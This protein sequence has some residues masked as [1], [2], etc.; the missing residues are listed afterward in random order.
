[1]KPVDGL[2]AERIL[3]WKQ[4]GDVAS[5]LAGLPRC[6]G[7]ARRTAF[8]ALQELDQRIGWAMV[9]VW[10][11]GR[12]D[13]ETPDQTLDRLWE[14]VALSGLTAGL[15]SEVPRVRAKAAAGMAAL[16]K[17]E[18]LGTLLSRMRL[19]RKGTVL[20]AMEAAV[21]ELSA[22]PG[23][24]DVRIRFWAETGQWDRIGRLGSDAATALADMARDRTAADRDTRIAR[25]RAL[26]T[27]ARIEPREAMDIVREVLESDR[28][29]LVLEAAARVLPEVGTPRDAPLLAGLLGSTDEQRRDAAM[30]ALE[31]LGGRA[32]VEVLEAYAAGVTSPEV[33]IALGEKVARMGGS[34]DLLASM[35][36]HGEPSIRASAAAA[37][38]RTG[39]VEAIEVL[40]PLLQDAYPSVRHEATVAMEA[41]GWV[42]VGYVRQWQT[43]AVD[44]WTVP[45]D[46]GAT[47][48]FDQ[49]NLMI[50]G[51]G[52]RDPI[53][54]RAAADMLGRLGAE[55]A[56]GPLEELLASEPDPT[57]RLAAARSLV[58]LGRP[59]QAGP[60]WAP[61]NAMEG[62]W[63][64]VIPHPEEA[65]A[66]VAMV[67]EL[68]DPGMRAAALEAAAKVDHPRATELLVQGLSDP[69]QRVRL[70]ATRGLATGRDHR[71][72]E[73]LV[74]LLD[75]PS[76]GP[77][78]ADALALARGRGAEALAEAARTASPA[79]R[80]RAVTLLGAS[81]DPSHL[82]TLLTA[83]KDEA[84]PVREAA[85]EGLGK[86]REQAATEALAELLD[87][88]PDWRVR[89]QAAR[90][91]GEARAGE[92][93]LVAALGDTFQE[94]RR[95]ALEALE[96]MGVPPAPELMRAVQALADE[97]WS[98]LVAIG[99]AAVPLLVRALDEREAD[100]RTTKTK[101][102]AAWA[103]GQIR[104]DRG[105]PALVLALQDPNPEVQAAAARAL[106]ELGA[107]SALP[108]I[109]ALAD[110]RDPEIRLAVLDALGSLGPGQAMDVVV[111][112]MDDPDPR[113]REKATRILGKDQEVAFD[114]LMEALSARDPGVRAAAAQ[115]LGTMGD[116][117][118]I[119]PLIELLG[120][121]ER[122][123]RKA[124][125]DALVALGWVPIGWRASRFDRGYSFWTKR[126]YWLG[127]DP[128]ASQ[129]ELL[130]AALEDPDPA[131]RRNA[132]EGLGRVGDRSAVGP[133]KTLVDDPSPHVAVVAC[134]ALVDLGEQPLVE[135]AWAPY[136][137]AR[138][139]WDTAVAIGAASV[140]HLAAVLEEPDAS[141]DRK[142]GAMEAL[143]RI[144]GDAAKVALL[145]GLEDPDPEPRG[146]AAAALGD[147]GAADAVGPLCAALEHRDTRHRV[148]QALIRIGPPA[149][150]RLVGLLKQA[151]AGVASAAAKILGEIG[152][153]TG[154][155]ALVEAM[156]RQEADVRAAAARA[157][158]ECRA[159]PAAPRLT[160]AVTA[161][162]A[163]RV[164]L[165]AA[166]ALGRVGDG[167]QAL[168]Q[169]LADPYPDVVRACA[170]AMEAIG[171]PPEPA[172]MNA[173]WA[174]SEERWDD[175]VAVGRAAIP[176]LQVVLG[177]RGTDHATCVRRCEAAGALAR[178]GATEATDGLVEATHAQD[179]RVVAAAARALGELGA[180]DALPRLVELARSPD[181]GVRAAAVAALG[182]IDPEGTMATIEA[183]M[184]DPAPEVR[185]AAVHALGKEGEIAFARLLEA[186]G[187]PDP[188]MR[189]AAAQTLGDLGDERG[190]DPL[191]RALSDSDS[192]VALAAKAALAKL[193]WMPV[194]WRTR[195]TDKGYAYWTTRSEWVEGLGD[196][197]QRDALEHALASS[198]D[199]VRRRV[200][201]EGLG[202]LG[203]DRAIPALKRALEEDQD[204]DVRIVAARSVVDLGGTPEVSPVWLPFWIDTGKWDVC[205]KIARK[206]PKS[207]MPELIGV[208]AGDPD[209]AHRMGVVQVLA[210]V[211][212][213]RAVEAL[214]SAARDHNPSV[215]EAALDALAARR[216]LPGGILED[217]ASLLG[218]DRALDSKIAAL[219]GSAFPAEEALRLVRGLAVHD[220]PARRVAAQI[221]AGYVQDPGAIQ[222]CLDGMVDPLARVRVAAIEALARRKAQDAGQRLV[223]VALGDP[224]WRVRRAAVVALGAIWEGQT[225]DD[226]VLDGLVAALGDP[227]GEVRSEAIRVAT[228]LG[229]PPGDGLLAAARAMAAGRWNEVQAHGHEAIPLL[230]RALMERGDDLE[231]LRT[232]AAAAR[233]LGR[234]HAPGAKELLLDMLGEQ[235]PRLRRAA[236]E[237]L[238]GLGDPTVGGAL[239]EAFQAADH[240][241]EVREA[242]VD[243][244]TRLDAP[245]T[246]DVIPLALGDPDPRVRAAGSRA[247]G[248]PGLME[249][250]DLIAALGSPDPDVRRDACAK[251]GELGDP[252]AIDPLNERLA[253]SHLPV[254]M[255]ARAALLALGWH[256]VGW[257][258]TREARG[259]SYWTFKSEWMG[260]DPD[261]PQ[262]SMLVRALDSEDPNRRRN[263]AEALGLMAATP[264]L[265]ALTRLAE[266]D[267]DEDVRL[268]AGDSLSL[269][270]E[271]QARIAGLA[272]AL[273][274]QLE[275]AAD[276]DMVID[277]SLEDDDQAMRV[278]AVRVLLARR[279]TR[280]LVSLLEHRAPE[281]RVEAARALGELGGD[282]AIRAL[283]R[284]LPDTLVGEAA[285][286]ALAKAGAVDRLVAATQSDSPQV[287]K[288]AVAALGHAG[289]DP[290]HVAKLLSDRDPRVRAACVAALAQL[291]HPDGRLVTMVLDDPDPWARAAA[292][293]A[294]GRLRLD[295]AQDAL[296]LAIADPARAVADAAL[297]ALSAT[298]APD[299]DEAT[300]IHGLISSED[301]AGCVQAPDWCRELLVRIVSTPPDGPLEVRRR[302]GAAWALG[303]LGGPAETLA[304][305]LES[306]RYDEQAVAAEALGKIGAKRVTAKVRGLVG[307]P[308]PGVRAASLEALGKLGDEPALRLMVEALGDDDPGVRLAA[309][310]ALGYMGEAGIGPLVDALRYEDQAMVLEACAS[311]A[312]IRDQRVIEDLVPL[313]R[314]GSPEVRAAAKAALEALG[315]TPVDVRLRAREMIAAAESEDPADRAAAAQALGVLGVQEAVPTL[316]AMLLDEDWGVRAAAGKAL[317]SL[318]RE[319]AREPAWVP[320]FAATGAW[321]DLIAMGTQGIEGL[322]HE[323]QDRSWPRRVQAMEALGRASGQAASDALKA[324]LDDPV[325]EVRVAAAK[326][327]ATAGA[328]EAVELLASRLGDEDAQPGIAEALSKFGEAMVE[329]ATRLLTDGDA[330][331]ARWAAT[332]LGMARI[333]APGLVGALDH[334]APEVR[335]AAAEAL[336]NGG[337]ASDLVID[338]L[339]DSF[340][341][342]PDP[343]VRVAAARA[344]GALGEGAEVLW[345]Y[346]G[347]QYG[348]VRRACVEALEAMG[349]PADPTLVAAGEAVAARRWAEV[350]RYGEVAV[351][352]LLQALAT[353]GLDRDSAEVRAGAALTLG[354]LG[355]TAAI[356]TLLEK[357]LRDQQ[358]A[359]RAAAA[360]ALG[361]LRAIEALPAIEAL[362]EDLDPAVRRAAYRAVADISGDGAVL[363]RGLDDPD[364]DVAATCFELLAKLDLAK[365]LAWAEVE[366][367]NPG[368]GRK[369]DIVE[370]LERLGRVEGVDVL[371]PLLDDGDPTVRRRAKEAMT[372]LGWLPVG[373]QRPGD[374]GVSYWTRRSDWDPAGPDEPQVSIMM[375]ALETSTDPEARFVAVRALGQLGDPTALPALRKALQQDESWDV[376]AEAGHALVSLGEGPMVTPAWLP[377][378]VSVEG[379]DQCRRLAPKAPG[380]AA[381]GVGAKAAD[382]A[383]RDRLAAVD[384]LL[385]IDHPEAV[386]SLLEL[387]RDRDPDVQK[388]ALTGLVEHR[389][390][391]DRFLE[392][393]DDPELGPIGVMALS[394]SLADLAR[395]EVKS[396]VQ[397]GTGEAR[398]RAIQIWLVIGDGSL[399][400]LDG[401]ETKDPADMARIL[402]LLDDLGS[403]DP[404]VRRRAVAG[405][406][407]YRDPGTAA[408]LTDALLDPEVSVQAGEVLVSMGVQPAPEP[409]WL[410]YLAAKGDWSTISRVG[411][412]A[413]ETLRGILETDPAQERRVGA[414]GALAGIPG[415]RSTALLV[416]AS[417]DPAPRVR[418][419]AAKALSA[420]GWP[421]AVE[422]LSGLLGDPDCEPEVAQTLAGLGPEAMDELVRVLEA[423]GPEART[424]A[425]VALGQ[426][427]EASALAPLLAAMDNPD[428]QVRAAA[429]R[430]LGLLGMPSAVD[431]LIAGVGDPKAEVR[432]AC[433]KALG[434]IGDP[435]AVEHL[436]PALGDGFAKVRSAVREALE[437]LGE[438]PDPE[439]LAAAE[440][441]ASERW[442]ALAAR[443]PDALVLVLG[444][445]GS[446]GL[447][448]TSAQTRASAAWVLGELGDQRAFEP[449][450]SALRDPIPRVQASAAL[451]LGRLGDQ[452]AEPHLV[453]AYASLAPEVRVA[454]LK[455]LGEIGTDLATRLFAGALD[456]P[457]PE[458]RAV[459]LTLLGRRDELAAADWLVQKL[460]E[461]DQEE[462]LSAIE[463]LV[464][465][466]A[467]RGIDG[468]VFC[469][470]D[471]SPAVRK[472][473]W[474]ALVA[475]GWYPI[476]WR[477]RR[478][479]PG[480]AYW[481]SRSDW[482][483]ATGMPEASTQKDILLEALAKAEDPVRR[484]VAAE[485][486]G[487]LGDP[488]ALPG[489]ER[490]MGSDPDEDVRIVA[491]QSMVRLGAE[492]THDRVWLPYWVA[493]G[494]WDVCVELHAVRE[495]ERVLGEPDARR[496]RGAIEA[497]ARIPGLD[498]GL[499]LVG[500]ATRD[501][502]LELRLLAL[503]GLEGHREPEVAKGL[504]ALLATP[505]LQ[506][507]VEE[508]LEGVGVE[509]VV[510]DL[511]RILQDGARP[512]AERASAARS[513]S[514]TSGAGE[515]LR[516]ALGAREGEVRAAA[517]HGLARLGAG[518]DLVRTITAAL[519]RDRDPM[520]RE[521]AAYALGKLG[522]KDA[523]AD[524]VGGMGDA[525]RE[526]RD[527]C[528]R[529]LEDLGFPPSR[530]VIEAS[531]AMAMERW[532]QVSGPAELLL[533]ALDDPATDPSAVERKANAALALGRSRS[534]KAKGVLLG[535]LTATEA[536]LVAAAAEALGVL[537]DPSA[538][539]ALAS[540]FHAP[541]QD[542][543]VRAAVV[544]GCGALDCQACKEVV[545]DALGDPDD[546]IRAMAFEVM[547]KPDQVLV[548][549]LI[550]AL[551]DSD[552]SV[553]EQ[554]AERLGAA[555]RTMAIDPLVATLGDAVPEVRR[556][557]K[558]ALLAL[559]WHPIGWRAHPDDKG[560]AYWTPRS[561]WLGADPDEPQVSMLIRALDHPD[562]DTRRNA[563]EALGIIGD[564]AAVGKL[565]TLA[566]GDPDPEVAAVA[567]QAL[568]DLRVKVLAARAEE[569]AREEEAE[570]EGVDE[571]EQQPPRPEG[572]ADALARIVTSVFTDAMDW[573]AGGTEGAGESSPAP[574]D[575]ARDPKE[576]DGPGAGPEPRDT[577]GAG[578][579]E[580]A[581]EEEQPEAAPEPRDTEGAGRA[582]EA[583]EEEQPEAHGGAGDPSGP[584]ETRAHAQAS[585]KEP[586]AGTTAPEPGT[587]EASTSSE[588]R[589]GEPDAPE[590][591]AEPD[592]KGGGGS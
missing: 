131:R 163:W 180:R 519:H 20:E 497:L 487:M 158:G 3:A 513:I 16:G 168:A 197:S 204:V 51:L 207:S 306:P 495:L 13:D 194:G 351:D 222:V 283:E 212:S 410:P 459:A 345:R 295:G 319:P 191:L 558:R 407:A 122:P 211:K 86:L 119:D 101:A 157:L 15:E 272:R 250:Q 307:S 344:L 225:P 337:L 45:S 430:G 584:L 441:L 169:G 526:V 282:E 174:I 139:D 395:P 591:G 468:L 589:V 292:A 57:V 223:D 280:R 224:S 84:A 561:M 453:R 560:Y 124:A 444:A 570:E 387:S 460:Y 178:L 316:E 210:R 82:D 214:L 585:T 506:A 156:D 393:L 56:S 50:R 557:A 281:V 73:R 396:L 333:E 47:G 447:D 514:R 546:R 321:D 142:A 498:A 141:P 438:A 257:R 291:G 482:L 338:A 123:V 418:M 352:L 138:G 110:H 389:E 209:P 4:L 251:L 310:R 386:E 422:I 576:H 233:T 366:I 54:R 548:E 277:V 165:E 467:R 476:G 448:R 428:G 177:E 330:T 299:L 95:A 167:V 271:T 442:E 146:A 475:L 565:E 65:V 377:Y 247:L 195:R 196:V 248:A 179:T 532:E 384:V 449:L 287:R 288:V 244:L 358:P 21:S 2:R 102:M 528:R 370:A 33:T 72:V 43:G 318:G 103:L 415:E 221:A 99:R 303:E 322:L 583:R 577:E 409:R 175:C 507:R 413:V 368:S 67:L 522:A 542:P 455:A 108:G 278:A 115:T 294:L 536:K 491:A 68:D 109:L 464:D 465:L 89:A 547:G 556:A 451:A 106:G 429:A 137:V 431:R 411:E 326:G 114:T 128:D 302:L 63:R 58:K 523:V 394:G 155:D 39:R 276:P 416:A 107:T 380:A 254:R 279:E 6:E 160:E 525:Y 289:A 301:W 485:G 572:L 133:L 237:G 117:R 305:L 341:R 26:E 113:V 188:G 530:E 53:M 421:A 269:I 5:I 563:A 193:G 400:V 22:L 420:R 263:A 104:D 286:R 376:R 164:R 550:Q 382:P 474:D 94:V 479:D 397:T 412:A 208:L 578:R 472:A 79:G 354:R 492:P 186:L 314:H 486:L 463:A 235:D 14:Q 227:Y 494:G 69:D 130:V 129:V 10:S 369:L 403:D 151:P 574:E 350:E 293:T 515:V 571:E 297:S 500:A 588:P 34:L 228:A 323:A 140:P 573:L 37:L 118:A 568:E 478:G 320:Y 529:S 199:P 80:V 64:D 414:L 381:R 25:V 405:L 172:T 71:G 38:A 512:S 432:A 176:L 452:R 517:L 406:G 1:M 502:S 213:D 483:E 200:A 470:S 83:T 239:F 217:L 121:S 18:A 545:A 317:V 81:G 531:R 290:T 496:R 469:L 70:A 437:D 590:T 246:R 30:D 348:E 218:R 360:E 408:R 275:T 374:K 260:D 149:V 161:D 300:S 489:L 226:A 336:A 183:A 134:Q 77:V 357:T 346:L 46:W 309:V 364:H 434:R 190:I 353:P 171:A 78:V 162:P 265:D 144:G 203:D 402:A 493:E 461:P 582:E 24:R 372:S 484:R 243:A 533:H 343:M 74:T 262:V 340:Q 477:V 501:P 154:V 87:H 378:W 383:T 551:Q 252:S 55:G 527:A 331:P 19:E 206:A 328:D 60:A 220:N 75:D 285:A 125:S 238:G 312:R 499:A 189:L 541:G 76:M 480:F 579:A 185:E 327:L 508:L 135:P 359:A 433:A 153:P 241:P 349:R 35:V 116:A 450:V 592:G 41:L 111:R 524:L 270:Q 373:W 473:A 581:R 375:R 215:A 404:A 40:A 255:A 552:P 205:G 334:P 424:W 436:L 11:A 187:S 458:V 96:A 29:P 564:P 315:F 132:A 419:D 562:P 347:D 392:V 580:E 445:L 540:T 388:A 98:E 267:P 539:P 538:G 371:V 166:M 198:P 7:E 332:S 417:R 399:P 9:Q 273:G 256:P 390:A 304:A 230:L 253:D 231:T 105:E 362:L 232:R 456:D 66:A 423:G 440:D 308:D 559:G 454:C 202:L 88:D 31:R 549:R 535:L 481:T 446:S 284:V 363:A 92:A 242:V 311:L 236:A 147:M 365:I 339:E 466:G 520:V 61:Y 170:A 537:G 566:S 534:P 569:E 325:P 298:Q 52:H 509:S 443:G 490:A 313:A 426:T 136:W 555:G 361:M 488:A 85:A 150:G 439:L 127:S 23:A 324:G 152:D 36:S 44:Y 126:S 543:M 261:E 511:V 100:P 62:H 379:W 427:G 554:A 182:R 112:G 435:A 575:D 518:P 521:A 201:A 27:L 268:V 159:R 355:A 553:R 219:M 266:S 148:S 184:R 259:Y 544:R 264:A 17:V 192:G 391:L 216:D 510:E 425:A 8:D 59:R 274:E 587:Q 586:A 32:A 245:Q 97:R 504:V 91:L 49:A 48:A 173:A 249:L 90:S 234:M 329:V 457:S 401:L 567:T 356:P 398:E 145:A 143:G 240:D 42:P 503:D 258:A 367:A 505:E 28:D 181:S 296:K 335:V 93:A 471:A 385:S 12:R 120:D 342:D 229:H 462:K 516:Q